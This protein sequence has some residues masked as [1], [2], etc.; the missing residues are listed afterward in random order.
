MN[1]PRVPKPVNITGARQSVFI[2][3]VPDHHNYLPFHI[4][5]VH[6]IGCF[7]CN[8]KAMSFSGTKRSRNSFNIE[9]FFFSIT[10]PHH[11]SRLYIYFAVKNGK[12]RKVPWARQKCLR[13]ARFEVQFSL[14]KAPWGPP[15]SAASWNSIRNS[16]GTHWP[17]GLQSVSWF[18]F[19]GWPSRL[20]QHPCLENTQ[21][22]TK[23]RELKERGPSKSPP[24]QC[25]SY[26][27]LSTLEIFRMAVRAIAWARNCLSRRSGASGGKVRPGR[28]AEGSRTTHPWDLTWWCSQKEANESFCIMLPVPPLFALVPGTTSGK[29]EGISVYLVWKRIHC[30]IRARCQS[31]LLE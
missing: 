10:Y 6:F 14:D 1:P 23:G 18:V 28:K 21:I 24:S 3:D 31:R 30:E 25:L 9:F 11:P 7:F 5:A 29:I 26:S 17:T 19:H 27:I 4:Y 15:G 16:A 13:E 20:P 12:S 22:H 8:P 2:P